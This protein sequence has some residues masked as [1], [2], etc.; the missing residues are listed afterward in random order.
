LAWRRTG[1]IGRPCPRRSI[2]TRRSIVRITRPHRLRRR[3][4]ISW[5]TARRISSRRSTPSIARS[6]RPV[7]GRAIHRPVHRIGRPIVR[8][9]IAPIAAVSRTTAVVHR[10]RVIPHIGRPIAT[11]PTAPRPM[12]VVDAMPPTPSPATPPPRLVTRDQSS[13]PDT[14]AEGNKRRCHNGARTWRSVHHRRVIL[15]YVDNLRIGRLNNIHRL[16]GDLLHL[17]LL[18]FI[19][20]QRA[21]GI[22]LRAQTLDRSS[23]LSLI[24][25]HGLPNCR[26]VVNVLRH[27]LKHARE[28][29]QS[30]KGRIESIT[31]CRI[32]LRSARKVRIFCQ[33]VINVEDL[34]RV[35]RG[36]RN[37][38]K[39]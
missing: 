9:P 18:L 16:A 29:Q 5:P 31:L 13:D 17:D 20:A 19:A 7:I 38:S 32:G 24:G 4:A 34:L 37:L 21:R 33:P 22:R 23:D 25:C 15:R 3:R 28:G 11:V 10:S 14:N 2:I 36:R 8:R 26:V 39:Q 6:S 1:S 35:G 12:I 27:H 30:K